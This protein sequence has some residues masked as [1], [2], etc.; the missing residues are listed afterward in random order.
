MG[1]ARFHCTTQLPDETDL[2]GRINAR[3]V[4]DL[5]WLNKIIKKVKSDNSFEVL[6]FGQEPSNT[7]FYGCNIW[8]FA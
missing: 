5:K 1:P 8:K 2:S 7:C 3:T 6:K 4:E